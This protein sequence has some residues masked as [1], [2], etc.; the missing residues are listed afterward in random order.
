[1]EFKWAEHPV[2]LEEVEPASV[3]VKRFAAGMSGRIA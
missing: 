3:I 1:M 2:P